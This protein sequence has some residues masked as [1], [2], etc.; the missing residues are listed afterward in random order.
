MRNELTQEWRMQGAVG[1][2]GGARTLLPR[3]ASLL[4]AIAA[5]LFAAALVAAALS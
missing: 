3:R 4:T 1:Q 5:W 2:V